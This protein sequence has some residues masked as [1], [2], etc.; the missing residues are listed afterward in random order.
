MN[1]KKEYI[2][3]T[4]NIMEL[5]YTGMLCNSGSSTPSQTPKF[6]T[7]DTE[8]TLPVKKGD[9]WSGEGELL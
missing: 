6:D 5:E 1:M 4:A 3:P 9:V 7:S 2:K 8:E